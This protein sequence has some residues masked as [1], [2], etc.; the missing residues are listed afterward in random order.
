MLKNYLACFI[1]WALLPTVSS[2]DTTDSVA[3]P[4]VGTCSLV[5]FAI[6]Y[7]YCYYKRSVKSERNRRTPQAP[8][9]NNR[10]E[11]RRYNQGQEVLEVSENENHK[12]VYNHGQEVDSSIINVQAENENN[13]KPAYN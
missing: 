4:I 6:I 11:T 5:I 10:E 13:N 1:L 2:Y 8:V 7:G 12:P 3:V 9:N